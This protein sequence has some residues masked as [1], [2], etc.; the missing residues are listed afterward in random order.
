M[1]FFKTTLLMLLAAFFVNAAFCENK[2]SVNEQTAK[3][4]TFWWILGPSMDKSD[5]DFQLEYM[6]KSNVGGVHIIPIYGERGDEKNYIEFLSPKFI[7]YVCY[8][9]EKAKSLGMGTDMTLGTGWPFGGRQITPELAAKKID[10]NFNIIPTNQKVKRA[11]FGGEGLVLDPF[12][13]RAIDEYYKPFYAAFKGVK[14]MP[15]RAVFDDSYEIFGADFS[16]V[17]YGEF[18]RLR[19][20]DF[21]DWQR[22]VLFN[23]NKTDEEQRVMQDYLETLSDLL[24]SAL[25][26]GFVDGARKL[27]VLTRNQAHGSPANI[28]DLYAMC[29]I[30]ETE[31]FGTSAFDIPLVRVDESYEFDRF[32]K[33]DFDMMK[34]ASSAAN[35]AKKPLVSS[36]TAT[37]LA[38]HFKVA[39]SQVKP[40]LD[41]LFA[42]GINHIVWHGTP[43][44]PKNKPWP[45][46]LFYASTNF[47]FNS[48]FGEYYAMLNKYV[49]NC[50]SLLQNSENCNEVLLYFPFHSFLKE[51]FLQFDVH[52]SWLGSNKNYAEILKGLRG[53]SFDHV[54]DDMLVNT[55][56][57]AKR[58]KVLIVP[59]SGQMPLQTAE[60][61]KRLAES[62]M[63]VVF[64]NSFP[65]SVPG[66]YKYAEKSA[67]LK[68]LTAQIA[69]NKNVF[70][71]NVFEIL[72]KQNVSYNPFFGQNGLVY[73]KKKQGDTRFYF[74]S[75]LANKFAYSKAEIDDAAKYVWFYNP[76]TNQKALIADA[77]CENGKTHFNLK[78]LPS[79]SLFI[80]FSDKKPDVENSTA[81]AKDGAAVELPE[82]F[83]FEFTAGYPDL[84]GK[85]YSGKKLVSW[86]SFPVENAKYYSGKGLYKFEFNLANA[87]KP[88][89]LDLG[90]VR[91]CAFV[92]INGR[93][94]AH[95]WSVPYRCE[96]P[97]G[98]LKS[99]KNTLEVEVLN[100]SFNRAIKLDID[101]V[102]W[103]NFRDI[104][105][106]D[107]TYKPINY[108]NAKP[109][110]SG[111]LGK[112]RLIEQ[113]TVK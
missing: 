34:F 76:L 89:V 13:R 92:R 43:Y 9:S 44:S 98:L 6:A 38:N 64:Q 87:E 70:K 100:L 91:E 73:I 45:G 16:D 97:R 15:I 85:K 46:R 11:A 36:E 104:N 108:A 69:K 50:Q 31:S 75:N 111:L 67:Q 80:F 25:T 4:W 93:P 56:D 71:G 12:N 52:G 33:P 40:Q 48:H 27:G 78:L 83:S 30:P 28:L 55:P 90:D 39:L 3:P 74:V 59:D 96:I 18:K 61:V 17:L 102:K 5:I 20:Y 8:I 49:Q 109:V 112:I 26:Q 19:G 79:Q 1:K 24:K 29:D 58:Y 103:R 54:S 72:K 37:W 14:P 62:G 113:N 10:K 60:A 65:Q 84:R 63:V 35:I 53:Y 23:A 105:F 88:Y 47:N 68:S 32:G 2:I 66:F 101:K 86:A 81:F 57:L 99:G 41:L 82:S 21:M 107:I 7:E 110:D 77:V 95:L 22:R 51:K 106:V 42:A 94:L